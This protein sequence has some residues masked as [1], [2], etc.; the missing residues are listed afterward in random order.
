MRS[1]G[2]GLVVVVEY[3]ESSMSEHLL[4]KFP[5]NSAF[6]FDYSQSSIWSPLVHRHFPPPPS[7]VSA[8]LSTTSQS[9]IPTLRKLSH[10][11]EKKEDKEDKELLLGTNLKQVTTNLRNKITTTLFDNFQNVSN[12]YTKMMK[13]RKTKKNKQKGHNFDFSSPS[14][15]TAKK[16]ASPRK[17]WAKILKVASKRFKKKKDL[18]AHN[19]NKQLFNSSI[20]GP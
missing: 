15:S 12:R 20:Y 3:L 11:D 10:E 14:L 9:D 13:Q 4:C 1:S 16:G 7:F 2:V 6:D 17:E 18:T 19:I 5:D 8:A